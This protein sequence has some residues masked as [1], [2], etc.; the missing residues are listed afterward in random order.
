MT[1]QTPQEW[2]KAT[3]ANVAAP[4]PYD[5][6][7]GSARSCDLYADITAEE[8]RA[9]AYISAELAAFTS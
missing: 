7:D 4:H 2:A 3:L 1:R 6:L 8:R 5:T 9:V